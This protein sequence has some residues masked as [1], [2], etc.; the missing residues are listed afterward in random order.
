[1]ASALARA[2]A[3]G[4]TTTAG[5]PSQSSCSIAPRAPTVALAL[6]RGRAQCARA[7]DRRAGPN[8][9]RAAAADA[10]SS[11]A[12]GNDEVLAAEGG[13][14]GTRLSPA[15][16]DAYAKRQAGR[17][18]SAVGRVS[19]GLASI[20]LVVVGPSTDLNEAVSRALGK[21]LGWFPVATRRVL[22]GLHKASEV[23]PEL[24]A[25]LREAEGPSPSSASD[26]DLVG[27]AEA[28]VLRGLSSQFRCCVATLGGRAS[29]VGAA[30]GAGSGA[31]DALRRQL[32]GT[33][34]LW[35]EEVD[36]R[37]AASKAASVVAASSIERATQEQRPYAALAE[38]RV[39]L[40]VST[41]GFG[42]A[43]NLSADQ[44]AEKAAGQIVTTLAKVLEQDEDM[45]A[46]K[47]Q[48]VEEVLIGRERLAAAA[49]ARAEAVERAQ[50]AMEEARRQQQQEGGGGGPGSS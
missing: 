23:G 45:G 35:V 28:E 4:A 21:R 31:Q 42:A 24:A 19:D 49:E 37:S 25:R 20:S 36:K 2:R 46:R 47:R 22:L 33:L 16:L 5:L 10:P 39:A 26:E 6:P 17:A 14:A 12:D 41:G 43:S 34:V 30:A 15:D 50:A 29:A 40:E 11:S 8:R 38:V 9:I 13:G 32:A 27:A 7:A 18:T 3:T 44:K 48:Y 1:M